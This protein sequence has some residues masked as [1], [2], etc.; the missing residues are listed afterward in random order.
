MSFR[1]FR[2]RWEWL[3]QSDPDR[4]W[5]LVS[6][7][8]RFNHDTGL[9][10]VEQSD[11]VDASSATPRRRLRFFKFGIPVEWEEEPFEWVRP[12]RFGVLRRYLSGPVAEMRVHVELERRLEGGTRMAYQVWARPKNLLGLAAIPIQIGIISRKRFDATIRRY[13]RFASREMQEE[14]PFRGLVHFTPGGRQ[15]LAEI[16]KALRARKGSEAIV[17]CLGSLIEQGDDMTVSRLRPYALADQW[18]KPRR[19]VLEHLLWATREGLV[20]FR[21][22]ILCPMCR[23]VKQ[24][25]LALGDIHTPVHCSSCNIDFYT[26]F[27]RSVELAFRVNPAIRPGIGGEFC[28]GGPQVTPHIIAQQL[29]P[30]VSMRTLTIPLEPGRYRVRAMGIPGGRFLEASAEGQGDAV[31]RALDEGW[32]TGAEGTSLNP[33]LRLE[34][35]T[36]RQQLFILERMT[37]NEQAVTAAEVTTL[38]LFRDLFSSEA[39][40]PGEQM[41]VGSLTLLFTDLRNSTRMYR[42][43]GDAVAFGRVMNHFDV[44]REAI[45]TE[46]GALVKTI[47]DA[48]M[49]AFVRPVGALKAILNA[50]SRLAHPPEGMIPL[51]LKAGMHY[52]P[53]IAVT[54]NDRLDYFGSTVNLAA[55][56]EGLAAAGGIVFS[57]KV[58]KDPEV[59]EFLS[60]NAENLQIESFNTQLKGFDEECFNLWRI[61]YRK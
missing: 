38:Q 14:I 59:E 46:G 8:N 41:S 6:D 33:A 60:R 36:N 53:C 49:A 18:R 21:W 22:D 28:V 11:I 7:T 31:V 39:L 50:Q 26:N 40:R 9:P 20:H 17:E 48:I 29:L 23:G 30:A 16:L 4:I 32:A 51:E 58:H 15:R 3:L 2:Y 44:L 45:D 52:G 34:N 1:E 61:L 19:A 47:G 5:P 54:L 10:S 24:T 37:W 25:N 56:L 55:R 27:D 13:D 12:Y 35:S 42:E 43:L 57:A